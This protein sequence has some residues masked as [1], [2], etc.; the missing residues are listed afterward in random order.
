MKAL[1]VGAGGISRQHLGCLK[2]LSG[3]DAI[4][5]CD[6]SP[7]TA[8]AMADRFALDGWWVDFA[9]ALGEVRPDVVHVTTPPAS[10]EPL[11]R[12]ALE[13][14]AHVLVEK[15]AT[16]TSV[17]TV[18][19]I[20]FAERQ[21]RLL[22]EDYNYIFNKGVQTAL[23][24]VRA[25]EYGEVIHVDVDIALNIYDEGSVFLDPTANRS[26]ARMKAGP[27]A[28]F[29]PHLASL[30]HA[31]IGPHRRVQSSWTH[32]HPATDFP[33]GFRALVDGE[34]ASAGVAFS[35]RAQP[36]RFVLRV[37][38]SRQRSQLNIFEGR[39]SR[40]RQ[41]AVAGPLV[42]LVNG[43]REGRDIGVGS[44]KSLSRKL[45]GGPGAYE[46]LWTLL[47]RF[48]DAVGAGGPAP[49]TPTQMRE[50]TA[51]VDALT[52]GCGQQ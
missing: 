32:A 21:G 47:G 4:H 1:V 46:G 24:A 22:V 23:D 10:H 12:R 41:L 28:D 15:P 35:A 19:L 52:E 44:L 29:L 30:A 27:V 3:V 20:D 50:V 51:L 48:Y 40:E 6:L 17:E 37:E 26:F 49:V 43:L 2:T 18:A 8:R 16:L 9:Q 34:R 11:A 14:G 38:G 39:D 33:D 5:V 13:S 45:S 7:V 31:F 25:G 42:P 36:D